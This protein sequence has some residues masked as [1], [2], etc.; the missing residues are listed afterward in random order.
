MKLAGNVSFAGVTG[1]SVISN[2]GGT[3]S[4]LSING[5]G[6]LVFDYTTPFADPDTL[7]ITGTDKFGNAISINFVVPLPY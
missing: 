2:Q 1:I 3:I 5:S 4:N 7:Q 6:Q